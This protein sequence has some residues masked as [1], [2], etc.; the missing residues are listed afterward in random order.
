[1]VDN[2]VDKNMFTKTGYSISLTP[3]R[4]FL[5]CSSL[6]LMFESRPPRN[7]KPSSHKIPHPQQSYNVVF[8]LLCCNKVS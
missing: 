2:K 7:K 4:L 3:I 5:L 1:M 6:T 8:C